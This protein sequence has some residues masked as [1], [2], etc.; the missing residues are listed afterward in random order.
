MHKKNKL[1]AIVAFAVALAFAMPVTAVANVGTIGV[2]SDSENISDIE[3][4]VEIFTNSD[5]SDTIETASDDEPIED[6]FI[7]PTMEDPVID[8]EEPPIVID[9]SGAVLAGNTTYVDDDFNSS[10]PGWGVTHFDNVKDGLDAAEDGDTLY[11]HNGTYY[12]NNIQ[13]NKQL[14]ITGESRTNTI[15]DGGTSYSG[16][17]EITADYVNISTLTSRK[18]YNNPSNN[19]AVG[20]Y[21]VKV[22]NIIIKDC[23]INNTRGK[24][25]GID[26]YYPTGAIDIINCEIYNT[27]YG[28]TV[29][30]A[31]NPTRIIDCDVHDNGL[32][33]Y[34]RETS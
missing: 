13:I 26:V 8:A 6:P 25:D 5:I 14:N 19:I 24:G 32:G 22:S 10:T 7:E 9:D 12:E 16:V 11:I 18:S 21:S 4:I 2:T 31:A 15:I 30:S 33:I 29:L 34:T 17:M 20:T 1:K 27:E 23:D 28:I 3:N